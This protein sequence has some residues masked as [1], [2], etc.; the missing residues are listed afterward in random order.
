MWFYKLCIW[1]KCTFFVWL[2]FDLEQFYIK[3][4]FWKKFLSDNKT[5]VFKLNKKKIMEYLGFRRDSTKPCV[6]RKDKLNGEETQ[7]KSKSLFATCPLKNSLDY[8]I[9]SPLIW[10]FFHFLSH[11]QLAIINSPRAPTL[12]LCSTR[13]P[14]FISHSPWVPKFHASYTR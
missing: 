8:T 3:R 11:F 7:S 13:Q 9:P 6:G 1:T 14:Y 2:V 12:V 10:P 5:R 4:F